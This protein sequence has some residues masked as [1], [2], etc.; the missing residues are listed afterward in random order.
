MNAIRPQYA[1]GARLQ[2][3]GQ[4][5]TVGPLWAA[6]D[7]TPAGIPACGVSVE[8]V[9]GPGR[10]VVYMVRDEHLHHWLVAEDHLKQ[11]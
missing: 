10:P 2:W 6:F 8:V 3:D 4:H 5:I 11:G 7:P 1:I 9:F